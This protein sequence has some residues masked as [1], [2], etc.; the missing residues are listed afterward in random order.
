MDDI[1]VLCGNHNDHTSH[2]NVI[3]LL[4]D[5]D[6]ENDDEEN[7]SEDFNWN[8]SDLKSCGNAKDPF[9]K[10]IDELNDKYDTLLKKQTEFQSE[11]FKKVED[12]ASKV[13]NKFNEQ[14][15]LLSNNKEIEVHQSKQKFTKINSLNSQTLVAQE[16]NVEY[17]QPYMKKRCVNE[18]TT[19]S[20]YVSPIKV[21]FCK[22]IP[23]SDP[24][25]PLIPPSH[26]GNHQF[27]DNPKL[28]RHHYRKIME[29]P[30]KKNRQYVSGAL[31]RNIFRNCTKIIDIREHGGTV[32]LLITTS[33]S[34]Q[35]TVRLRDISKYDNL[36]IDSFSFVENAPLKSKVRVGKGDIGSMCC[37]G[38]HCKKSNGNNMNYVVMDQISSKSSSIISTYMKRMKNILRETLPDES[39]T[40]VQS[41]KKQNIAVGK[42][43]GGVDGLSA[44]VTVTRDYCNAPHIDLD[45]SMTMILQLQKKENTAVDWGTILENTTISTDQHKKA[46]V[47]VN[48]SGLLIGI[49]ARI[50]RHAT[51]L[52][53]LKDNNHVYGIGFYSKLYKTMNFKK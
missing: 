15:V 2:Q 29:K 49:D 5:L 34:T 16:H 12:I 32:D 42:E 4:S 45:D 23:I 31:H 41:L 14:L 39:Q 33:N 17:K 10:S 52:G 19:V 35:T 51:S 28:S 30:N 44:S 25:T 7:H 9:S 36:L 24:S 3:S 22:Q 27:I 50:I 11:I 1:G 38:L 20:P 21:I 18:A 53:E 40:I 8:D 43:M 13:T 26:I 48:F 6:D 46:V 37:L 47:I